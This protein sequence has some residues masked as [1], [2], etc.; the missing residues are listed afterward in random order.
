M[1]RHD[2]TDCLET[3]TNRRSSGPAKRAAGITAAMS[4]AMLTAAGAAL[5]IPSTS[6]GAPVALAGASVGQAEDYDTALLALSGSEAAE[7]ISGR[8][9]ALALTSSRSA[10]RG[11]LPDKA[12]EPDPEPEPEVVG[13][14]FATAGVNVRKAPKTDAKVVDVLD[15]GDKVRVTDQKDDGWR[16]VKL[17]G[18][19]YWVNADYLSKS[20]P[21]APSSSSG[22]SSSGG[23]STAACSNGSSASGG[24]NVVAV[25]RA[26]CAQFPQLTSYGTYRSGSGAHSSGRAIDIMVSGSTGQQV[27]DYVRANASQL[28]VTEVIYAQRIWT[29]QRA[30][31]GWR[32]MSNR[33]SATANH[34]D[35]VHVTVR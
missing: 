12:E 2:S 20:K 27:A 32:G 30:G 23:V 19:T 24:A 6:T 18:E 22:S 28:G 1:S 10:D 13:T 26:V 21:K 35:H 5:A 25:H 33:G 31:D 29:T 16:Q 17:K 3:P 34:Y 15:H 11:E 7:A 8:E 9:A 4:L 14:R